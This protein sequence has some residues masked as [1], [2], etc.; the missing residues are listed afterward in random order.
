[1][2]KFLFLLTILIFISPAYA[3]SLGEAVDRSIHNNHQIKS[4]SYEVDVAK[5]KISTARSYAQPTLNLSGAYIHMDSEP[6]KPIPAMTI[7]LGRMGSLPLHLPDMKLTDK[8]LSGAAVTLSYPLYTGGRVSHAVREAEF[9]VKASTEKLSEV[10]NQVAF[11]TVKTYLTA[12]LAREAEAVYAQSAATVSEHL[13][14]AKKLFEQKQIAGYEVTRAKSMFQKSLADSE[15]ASSQTKI[16]YAALNTIMGEDPA[17]PLTL[18]SGFIVPTEPESNGSV[19]DNAVSASHALKALK[20]K[21]SVLKEA[22]SAALADKTPKVG[23]IV[24]KS[25]YT[26]VKDLNLPSYF[27]GVIVDI[28]IWDGGKANAAAREQRA[29]IAKNKEEMAASENSIRLSIIQYQLE[30]NNAI[31]AMKAATKSEQYATECLR[32]AKLRFSEGVG[33]GLEITDANLALSSA[34]LTKL[35]AEYDYSV[36]VYGIASSLDRLYELLNL[37]DKVRVSE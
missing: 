1:M 22:E 17:T 16:A 35:K 36:A 28:P 8:D 24:S 19:A 5:S 31:Q 21:G 27:G 32:L 7:P 33:T 20:Y 4:T 11:L 25:I 9:G 30:R 3:L 12:L 18:D 23:L 13:E 34:R 15:N 2:K 29:L 14:N 26:S 10:E 37:T 6:S